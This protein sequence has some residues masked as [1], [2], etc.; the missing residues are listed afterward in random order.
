MA[1]GGSKYKSVSSHGAPA[2]NLWDI[3][4]RCAT[5]P[6]R[7]SELQSCSPLID[8]FL[9]DRHYAFVMADAA[10][11]V[12]PRERVFRCRGRCDAPD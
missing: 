11:E 2:T 5:R 10:R 6:W 7:T 9:D 8:H 1:L 12:Q 3:L 4:K